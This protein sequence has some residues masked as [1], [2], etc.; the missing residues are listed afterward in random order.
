MNIF[1]RNLS[2]LTAFAC[3][4]GITLFASKSI[5]QSS[6]VPSEQDSLFSSEQAKIEYQQVVVANTPRPTGSEANLN[7]VNNIYSYL[8]DLGLQVELQQQLVCNHTSLQCSEVVNVV[9]RSSSYRGEN[10]VLVTTHHD[11]VPA[12]SGDADPGAGMMIALELAKHRLMDE[13]LMLLFT[14]GEEIGL[15]GAKAFIEHHS[16]AK[17][18]KSVINLEARG[19]SGP[20]LIF[21]TGKDNYSTVSAMTQ[22]LVRPLASSFFTGVYE[23][24][25]NNTDFTLYKQAGYQ[26]A[27]FAFIGSS[28]HYHTDAD[29]LHN[30]SLQSVQHQGENALRLATHMLSNKKSNHDKDN[31]AFSDLLTVKLFSWPLEWTPLILFIFIGVFCVLVWHLE[32]IKRLEIDVLMFQM[33]VWVGVLLLAAVFGWGI[34]FFHLSEHSTPYLMIVSML[35]GLLYPLFSTFGRDR[36]SIALV[37]WLGVFFLSLIL[38]LA[39]PSLVAP[40]LPL[41]GLV[42]VVLITAVKLNKYPTL[43]FILFIGV[44]MVTMVSLWTISELLYL[45]M[46]YQYPIALLVLW[47]L[48]GTLLSSSLSMLAIPEQAK[49]LSISGAFIV[50]VLAVTNA[51]HTKTDHLNYINLQNAEGESFLIAFG[52]TRTAQNSSHDLYQTPMREYYPWAPGYLSYGLPLPTAESKLPEL[53]NIVAQDSGKYLVSIPTTTTTDSLMLI[54]PKQNLEVISIAGEHIKVTPGQGNQV[55][56][57][58]K[59]TDSLKHIELSY[60]GQPDGHAYM[61]LKNWGLENEG[62]ELPSG[63]RLQFSEGDTTMQVHSLKL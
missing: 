1:I 13:G 37:P 25:P 51:Q 31:L 54:V 18:V 48:A 17:Q 36:Y 45:A 2:W 53:F 8:K 49:W 50:A 11:T 14:D 27:N 32:K 34:G 4:A 42:F 58:Y 57:F 38:L 29:N 59:L 5:L 6:L 55:V 41:L 24:M 56:H 7:T 39:N 20:S 22:A 60:S 62:L 40:V 61:V 63:E 15:L 23:L 16:W 30:L 9:A 26:G 21:E 44:A 10:Y 35:L 46:G 43:M 19:T 28:E 12:S 33:L 3:L 52:N 47:T